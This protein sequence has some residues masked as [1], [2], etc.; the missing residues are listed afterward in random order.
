MRHP[1]L[2][3]ACLATALSCVVAPGVPCARTLDPAAL[4]ALL[5]NHRLGHTQRGRYFGEEIHYPDGSTVWRYDD[6]VQPGECLHGRWWLRGNSVCYRY[7]GV[8]TSNCVT[9]EWRDGILF[10]QSRLASGEVSDESRVHLHPRGPLACA[11]S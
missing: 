6:A 11:G 2:L 8:E 5:V 3:T 7:E 10:S 1:T 9:Y 4:R